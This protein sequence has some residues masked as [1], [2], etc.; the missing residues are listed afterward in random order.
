MENLK[1]YLADAGWLAWAVLFLV[2]AL[3]YVAALFGVYCTTCGNKRWIPTYSGDEMRQ[4]DCPSCKQDI[5][6]W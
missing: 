4:M 6:G 5:V 1:Q 2:I 3:R